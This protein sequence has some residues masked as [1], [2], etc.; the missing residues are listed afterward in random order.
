MKPKKE[1]GIFVPIWEFEDPLKILILKILKQQKRMKSKQSQMDRKLI[2]SQANNINVYF[3]LDFVM[4][5]LKC[6]AD[7]ALWFLYYD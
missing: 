1:E 2:S 3:M 5:Y 7:Y 4:Y 6:S